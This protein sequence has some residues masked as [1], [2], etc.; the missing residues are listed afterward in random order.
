MMKRRNF[1]TLLGG[2]AAAWPL[3]PTYREVRAFRLIYFGIIGDLESAGMAGADASAWSSCDTFMSF[4]QVWP[5]QS[6][7]ASFVSTR[8]G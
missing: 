6:S 1:I 3:G 7:I 5:H 4:P 8:S 2:A